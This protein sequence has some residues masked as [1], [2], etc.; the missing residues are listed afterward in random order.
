[1]GKFMFI[2]DD[3]YTFLTRVA[4]ALEEEG[5]IDKVNSKATYEELRQFIELED[6]EV[7]FRYN[8]FMPSSFNMFTDKPADSWTGMSFASIMTP[9]NENEISLGFDY[10]F[11]NGSETTLSISVEVYNGDNELLA[12]SNPIN[13]P[14]VRSK[15]TIVRG[16]FL[17]LDASGGVCINPGYDGDDYNIEIK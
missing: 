12:A 2:S 9:I 6:Y 10:V 4:K 11:V 7:R 1:M 8:M 14:I 16:A 17:T 13:V 15:L 5:K 3:F